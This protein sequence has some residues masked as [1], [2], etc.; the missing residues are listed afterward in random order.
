MKYV[1]MI[2]C[3]LML[4]FIVVQYNDPDGPLWMLIYAVPTIWAALAA[5]RL[6]SI[7]GD[8]A[9]VLMGLSIAAMLLL[10]LYYW[11]H[12]EGFWRKDIWWI[13]ETAREGMGMMIASLVT[14]V[15]G[16]TIWSARKN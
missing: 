14:L 10:T 15:A 6:N 8:R 9:F 7:L 5:F 2:L 16:Y 1:N 13:K 11:P 12:T 3:A 4:L